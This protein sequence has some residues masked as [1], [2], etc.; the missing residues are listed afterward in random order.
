MVVKCCQMRGRGE[1]ALLKVCIQEWAEEGRESKR[2]RLEGIAQFIK[3]WVRLQD[4]LNTRY[5]EICR[6][7]FEGA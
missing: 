6:Y 2:A 1:L 7:A 4:F 5:P 3:T